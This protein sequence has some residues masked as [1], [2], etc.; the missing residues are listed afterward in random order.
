[1]KLHVTEE[2]KQEKLVKLNILNG[3]TT[4]AVQIIKRNGL[5]TDGH[6]YNLKIES[7][8]GESDEKNF[9]KVNHR[10]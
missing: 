6:R 4:K 10:K 9:T 5:Q 1:M 3:I 7:H 2:I 8:K